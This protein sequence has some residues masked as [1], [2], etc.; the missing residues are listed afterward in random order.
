MVVSG[1]VSL[2]GLVCAGVQVC[3]GSGCA[4]LILVVLFEASAPGLVPVP[5]QDQCTMS[6]FQHKNLSW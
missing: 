5:L 3:V 2:Y 4:V 6:S 1:S